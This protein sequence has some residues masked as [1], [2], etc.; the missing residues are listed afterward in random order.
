MDLD[1]DGPAPG[2]EQGLSEEVAEAQPDAD[3]FFVSRARERKGRYRR[4]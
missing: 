1:I 2:A 3:D 4:R